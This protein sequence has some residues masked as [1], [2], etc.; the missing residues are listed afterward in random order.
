MQI[1]LLS[2]VS[3]RKYIIMSEFKSLFYHYIG[4]KFFLSLLISIL[5][6]L[7]V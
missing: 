5:Y 3:Q 1:T 2:R 4:N 6:I 7:R